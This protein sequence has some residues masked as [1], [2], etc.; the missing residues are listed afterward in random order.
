VLANIGTVATN[1][2]ERQLILGV[3]L[4]Y[5]EDFY[6]DFCM[7]L[8]D[9]HTIGAIT[10]QEMERAMT[11]KRHDLNS[12]LIRRYQEPKVVELVNKLKIAMPQQESRWNDILS[13]AAYT[14][15]LEKVAMWLWQ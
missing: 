9:A 12:C 14:N 6:I 8:C 10:P 5:G 13:G 1:N 3:G 4:Q 15:Y 7:E 11:P 2:L